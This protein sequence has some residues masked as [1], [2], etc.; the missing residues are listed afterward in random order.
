MSRQRHSAAPGPP[1]HA[2]LPRCV[3]LASL[4]CALAAASLQLPV[5]AQS[6]AELALQNSEVVG[7]STSHILL[8]PLMEQVQ[9]AYRLV[10]PNTQLTIRFGHTRDVQVRDRRR[11]GRGGEQQRVAQVADR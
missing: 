9:L 1:C 5:L 4:L 10:A 8:E 6:R 11:E 7:V 2:G 3:L